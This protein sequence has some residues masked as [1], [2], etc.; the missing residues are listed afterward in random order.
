MGQKEKE[1]VYAC[2]CVRLC[3][4]FILFDFFLNPPTQFLFIA[5][6]VIILYGLRS[7]F[8][9]P[10]ARERERK[11]KTFYSP[12]RSDKRVFIGEKRDERMDTNRTLLQRAV[13]IKAY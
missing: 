11:K 3:V 4:T 8:L 13:L 7:L 5:A 9:Y 1:T 2:V 6:V 12:L 10:S